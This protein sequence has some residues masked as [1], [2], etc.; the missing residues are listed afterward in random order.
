MSLS[1]YHRA[2]CCSLFRQPLV[3]CCSTGLLDTNGQI[4]PK[5]SMARED[6]S[7]TAVT[8]RGRGAL[9]ASGHCRPP[10]MWKG[11]YLTLE[12]HR[13]GKALLVAAERIYKLRSKK[14][15]GTI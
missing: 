2:A 5:W 13:S 12:T 3:R 7:G 1:S 10:I 8:Q 15:L 9:N 14:T 6:W 11:L 4:T